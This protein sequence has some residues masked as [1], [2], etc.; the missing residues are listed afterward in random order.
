[1]AI[2]RRYGRAFTHAALFA[3]DLADLK[4]GRRGEFGHSALKLE[5]LLLLASIDRFGDSRLEVE[6]LFV[7]ELVDA[8]YGHIGFTFIA[9]IV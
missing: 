8:G 6:Q 2:L 9:V 7:R 1:M 5:F 3:Q 4:S